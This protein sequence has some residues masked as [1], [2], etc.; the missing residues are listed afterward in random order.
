[1]TSEPW[2]TEWD[3]EEASRSKVSKRRKPI[4]KPSLSTISKVVR[5]F[6]GGGYLEGQWVDQELNRRRRLSMTPTDVGSGLCWKTS[7]ISS[8]NGRRHFADLCREFY[9]CSGNVAERN[10]P[11]PGQPVEL[12]PGGG[13][14][15][16]G[17]AGYCFLVT[18][19]TLGYHGLAEG[20]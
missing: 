5:G 18:M 3:I 6:L 19:F 14:I 13:E 20:L 15:D 16:P 4:W 11:K 12:W 10:L 17:L 7:G 1:M 8:N 2:L 9:G